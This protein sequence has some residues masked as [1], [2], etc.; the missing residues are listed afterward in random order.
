M[1]K[2]VTLC[3]FA[4]ALLVGT[5]NINAQEV[6]TNE[7][8]YSKT[9]ELH[10]TLKFDND[11]FKKVYKAYQEYSSKTNTLETTHNSG[12]ESYKKYN[13]IIKSRLLKQM[14]SALS[15]DIYKRYLILTNQEEE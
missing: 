12:T 6:E 13:K 8:A 10:K 4:F 11:T 9:K 2:L 15:P 1:K 7:I 3:I 5:Q 14:K